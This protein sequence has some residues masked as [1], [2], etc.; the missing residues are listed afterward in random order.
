MIFNYTGFVYSLIGGLIP[1]GLLFLLAFFYKKG[2]GMGDVK[3]VA[4]VGVFAGYIN[5]LMGIF[6]GALI[7][8]IIF[9]PL[10]IVDKI[11]RK[12]RIPFGPLISLGTVI[13]IL[14]GNKLINWYLG[15]FV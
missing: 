3:L 8:S 10:L 7:G 11:D 6:L 12:T 15:I 5:G 14:Y 9:L 13:M 1:A 2:M 4:M